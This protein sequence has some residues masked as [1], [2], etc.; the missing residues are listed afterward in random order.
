MPVSFIEPFDGNDNLVGLDLSQLPRFADVFRAAEQTGLVAASAPMSQALVAGTRGPTVLL[1][2]PLRPARA[3]DDDAAA[4]PTLGYALG[5]LQL[6]TLIQDAIGPSGAPVE[7]A[8]AYQ[9]NPQQAAMVFG[10]DAAARP[11]QPPTGSRAPPSTRKCRSISPGGISCW[12][13]VR[14]VLPMP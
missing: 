4:M 6:Q 3:A 13:C 9:D 14:S 11:G 10:S 2:F 8:V 7:A 12:P 1:A 5:I